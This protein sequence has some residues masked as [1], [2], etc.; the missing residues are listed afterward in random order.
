[1]IDTNVPD[2][3]SLVAGAMDAKKSTK[4]GTPNEHDKT[5]VPMEEAMWHQLRPIMHI[6]GDVADGWERFAKYGLLLKDD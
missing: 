1:M 2:P 3:T 5:K 6:I 4:D